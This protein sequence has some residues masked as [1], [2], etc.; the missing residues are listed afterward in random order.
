MDIRHE[1]H[2]SSWYSSKCDCQESR[3]PHAHRSINTDFLHDAD[4]LELESSHPAA[5]T[6]LRG[7]NN[8]RELQYME[9]V[10]K[11]SGL[12]PDYVA[13]RIAEL[14]TLGVGLP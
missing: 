2:C 3:P 10:G 7:R 12:N 5:A 4:W 1:D 13:H 6:F 9:T 14:R 11:A 8:S